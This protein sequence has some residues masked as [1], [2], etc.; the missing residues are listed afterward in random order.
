MKLRRVVY[1]SFVEPELTLCSKGTLPETSLAFGWLRLRSPTAGGTGSIAGRGAK[2]PE[3]ARC[4]PRKGGPFYPSLLLEVALSVF[5]FFL[6]SWN[7]NKLWPFSSQEGK[8]P[9]DPE[10]H[11]ATHYALLH[12][13]RALQ[14]RLTL[15]YCREHIA[16]G[17]KSSFLICLCIN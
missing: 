17:R 14:W 13:C 10:S 4:G 15:S 2:I 9:L 5:Y 3:A 11:F 12:N 8:F 6:L 7:V 1:T 16:V